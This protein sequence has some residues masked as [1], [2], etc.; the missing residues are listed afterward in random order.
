MPLFVVPPI[1]GFNGRFDVGWPI[2][3]RSSGGGADIFSYLTI[4]VINSG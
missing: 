3:G 4:S 2:V 1:H